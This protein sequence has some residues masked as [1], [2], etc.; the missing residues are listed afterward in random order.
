MRL[1]NIK[2]TNFR[3]YADAEADLPDG[4]TGILGHNGAGK[5]T[6]LEAVGWVLYGHPA[7]RTGKEDIRRQGSAEGEI[8]RVELTFELG[9]AEYTV[10]REMRGKNLTAD[11]SVITGGEVIARG[12]QPALEYVER[13]LGL[14]REAFFISFFARQKELNALSDYKPAERKTMIIRM[15]GIDD[16]DRAIELARQDGRDGQTRLAAMRQNLA[17]PVS[18]Q[19][20][21]TGAANEER[22][23]RERLASARQAV[24]AVETELARAK[25]AYEAAEANKA[26]SEERTRLRQ[27]AAQNV[28]HFRASLSEKQAELDDLSNKKAGRDA[29]APALRFE[30]QAAL[31]AAEAAAETA[32]AALAEA[33]TNME[34][35]ADRQ[36]VIRS[37]LAAAAAR[38]DQDGLALDKLRQDAGVVEGIGAGGVCP[39]CHQKI[40]DVGQ[41]KAHIETE[42]SAIERRMLDTDKAIESLKTAESEN[43]QNA[44]LAKTNLEAARAQAAAAGEI[45]QRVV[46][47]IESLPQSESK[48]DSTFLAPGLATEDKLRY[49]AERRDEVKRLDVTL[50]RLPEVTA[51]AADLRVKIAEA[52]AVAAQE[53]TG[54]EA[55]FDERAYAAA[56]ES[57]D[58]ARDE[59]HRRELEVKDLEGAA[60]V[61]AERSAALKR[62]QEAYDRVAADIKALQDSQAGLST[63][64]EALK[65][66]R[67]HLIGR[68]RP[69]LA[70]KAGE[71]LADLT[72][73]KYTEIDLDDD[74]EI[75]ITDNGRRFPV[76]R[77]SGGEKDLANLCLRL[78]ISLTLADRAGSDYGFIVLD[79]IFGSQDAV[80][81]M[82]I[83]RSLAALDK[84]FRQIF[85]ITHV[86]DI[87]EEVENVIEVT[88]TEAGLSQLKLI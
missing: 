61:A 78:A 33:E 43:T 48:R 88:E 40:S 54:G 46:R 22:L 14:D 52:E 41:I 17:D 57:F 32:R 3:K 35:A 75:F 36:N 34:A 10:V 42:A 16:V 83:M 25:A 51:A 7:A 74:Y 49:L 44:A 5:S 9:G 50:A 77:F 2:L 65:E 27:L 28:E 68:I 87:K 53:E 39:T 79:E 80:R 62:E 64:V 29:I 71:L 21:L 73:G 18:L 66:F 20:A 82:N 86:E 84:R 55:L 45:R 4:L 60:A 47:L 13:L 67:T 81:K 31:E 63:L 8:A 30:A 26:T 15:L 23:A 59:K 6:L 56:R 69:M 85:L 1:V 70:E 37:E 38:R 58:A 72:D 19:A 76:D 12:A 11:A 24:E